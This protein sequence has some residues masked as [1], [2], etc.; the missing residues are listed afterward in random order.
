[1]LLFFFFCSAGNSHSSG[2]WKIQD[3]GAAGLV[4]GDGLL[5]ASKMVPYCYIV[6]KVQTMTSHDR[7]WKGKRYP[8]KYPVKHLL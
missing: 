7:W 1:V 6:Q 5:S 8:V 2:G 3:Q 4:S